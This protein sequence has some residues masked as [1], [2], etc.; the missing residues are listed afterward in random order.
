MA[1]KPA[2]KQA[3]GALQRIR[4]PLLRAGGWLVVAAL[5]TGA[6]A[7][8]SV[9]GWQA[10]AGNG[11]FTLSSISISPPAPDAH[12]RVE[13][14]AAELGREV[15]DVL[16]GRSVF[17]QNVCWQLGHELSASPW[18]LRVRSIRRVLP[19]TLEA[20]I[21]FRKPAAPV[22]WGGKTFIVD[23]DGVWLPDEAFG[24]LY[25]SPEAWHRTDAPAMLDRAL[26][27]YPPRGRPWG[28]P[29]EAPGARL[30][31]GARLYGYLEEEGLFNELPIKSVDVTGVGT[32][33]GSGSEPEISL[34]TRDGVH[35]KWGMCDAYQ[36]V[37]GL[38]HRRPVYPDERKLG[39]L[40]KKL[41]EYPGLCGLAYI[42]LRY[43]EIVTLAGPSIPSRPGR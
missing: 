13:A 20:D 40:R 12:V 3:P 35:I 24:G 42:D 31:V 14:M 43:N 9:R 30:A 17:D 18:V 38:D 34:F 1:K 22:E 28:G 32:R 2:K 8:G 15:G 6:V 36:D 33:S 25:D 27:A 5:L 29:P 37:P 26:R 4:R 7:L 23:A 21:V 16:E 10:V 11:R 41:Q 19:D 39:M